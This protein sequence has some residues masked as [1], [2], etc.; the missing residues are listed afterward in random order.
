MAG[1]ILDTVDC[2]RN[3]AVAIAA[4]DHYSG[5]QGEAQWFGQAVAS[6]TRVHLDLLRSAMVEGI[7]EQVEKQVDD[8]Y[9]LTRAHEIV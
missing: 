9:K 6:S 2:P 7:G 1:Q 4:R 5:S 3:V 8:C